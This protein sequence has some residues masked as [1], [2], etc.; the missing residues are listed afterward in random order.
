MAGQHET[1]QHMEGQH[2]EGHAM[3]HAAQKGPQFCT[4]SHQQIPVGTLAFD[5]VVHP[6]PVAW[7]IAPEDDLHFV[8]LQT[9][10]DPIFVDEQFRP[11]WLYS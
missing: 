2:T 3:P 7:H 6:D 8:P 10:T 5:K 1:G 11:P 9:L 4:C